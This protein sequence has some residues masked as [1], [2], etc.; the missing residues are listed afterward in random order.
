[1]SQNKSKSTKSSK[2]NNSKQTPT[3]T[4]TES[5]DIA[6]PLPPKESAIET[7]SLVPN[8]VPVKSHST[9]EIQKIYSTSESAINC[10]ATIEKESACEESN[11]NNNNY[12][13][14]EI[15]TESKTEKPTDALVPKSSYP[16]LLIR[17]LEYRWKKTKETIRRVG[18]KIG[19]AV[20]FMAADIEEKVSK[21]WRSI[22]EKIQSMKERIKNLVTREERDPEEVEINSKVNEEVE[23]DSSSESSSEEEESN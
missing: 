11:N 16:N 22:K 4:M 8:L 14:N 18:I 12:N 10:S 7:I 13:S 15:C 19:C 2:K 6:T 3:I 23:S 5:K 17:Y 21:S 1:M 20:G 9:S